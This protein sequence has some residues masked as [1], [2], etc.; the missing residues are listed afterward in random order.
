M[1]ILV[2]VGVAIA[3]TYFAAT[4]AISVRIRN[5]GLLDV[6][7][8]YGVAILAPMYAWFGPSYP[9]REFRSPRNTR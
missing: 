4:W 3:L 5:Y 1:T 8:S 7:F 2:T 6:A 9:L